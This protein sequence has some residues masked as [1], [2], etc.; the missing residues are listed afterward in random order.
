MKPTFGVII[1]VLLL[2]MS[3]SCLT[4]KAKDEPIKPKYLPSE[5][6]VYDKIQVGKF[7][8]YLPD[9]L[10][11]S[12][13]SDLVVRRIADTFSIEFNPDS[14]YARDYPRDTIICDDCE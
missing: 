11:G 4:E 5:V 10:E 7:T 3:I 14:I 13:G 1:G 2:V 6:G 9:E 8:I 12:T